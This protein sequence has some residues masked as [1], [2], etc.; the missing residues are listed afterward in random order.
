MKPIVSI[1]R[2]EQSLEKAVEESLRQIGG[3]DTIVRQAGRVIIKPNFTCALTPETGAITDPAIV[4]T[5]AEKALSAGASEVIV[6]EAMGSGDA[7]LD[8]INGLDAIARM[9]GVR[10]IDLNDAPTDHIQVA[11][12]LAVEAFDIPRI[13]LKCDVLINLAKLKVHPQ[14]MVSIGMKNLLGILPGRSFRDPEEAKRQ[15]YLTP[16]IPGDGKRIF[17]DLARDHG[18]E[19]MQDAI[20]DLNTV[21]PSHLIIVDAIY[22]MEGKGSPTRGKPVKM[23]LILAGTDVVAVEAVASFIMGFDP[24]HM[25]YLRH[26]VEK[27]VG[28][29]YRLENIDIRGQQAD[30]VCRKFE[31]ASAKSLWTDTCEVEQLE[32]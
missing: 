15:G 19:A 23:D 10:I 5:L 21:V 29:E 11:D 6:A 4:K 18:Q 31:R 13:V 1:V 2:K 22:A 3:I 17:H 7:R 32:T 16:I 27:G 24:N 28:C 20:V 26:A 14:A 8:D 9:K 12:A 30:A 25:A